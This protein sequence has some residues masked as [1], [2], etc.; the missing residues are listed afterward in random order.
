MCRGPQ[1]NTNNTE[2][3]YLSRS[4]GSEIIA[5]CRCVRSSEDYTGATQMTSSTI[6]DVW[7]TQ[8]YTIDMLFLNS[9]TCTKFQS[10]F[11]LT[12]QP[13]SEPIPHCP[14]PLLQHSS[15]MSAPYTRHTFS[16]RSAPRPNGN[17]SHAVLQQS[18][19]LHVAGWMG[20]DPATGKIVEGGIGPQTVSYSSNK[21]R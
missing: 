2:V 10:I 9:G 20:D 14:T 12:T 5:F 8:A 18:A 6:I 13:P 15:S 21:Q 16:S 11:N 7:C 17:Y 1:H 19:A 3:H 4:M